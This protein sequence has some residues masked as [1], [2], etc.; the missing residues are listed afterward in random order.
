MSKENSKEI[1]YNEILVH[2]RKKLKENNLSIR[3]LALNCELD[4]SSF[5]RMLN[6]S[7]EPKVNTLI[8]IIRDG[9]NMPLSEFFK[10]FD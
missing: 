7:R 10:D 2:V 9:L 1:T 4:R 8:R 3:K 5:H 6:G